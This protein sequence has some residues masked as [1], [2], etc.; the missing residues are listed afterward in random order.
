M[1][2]SID[3][4]TQRL[5]ERDHRQAEITRDTRQAA[6]ATILRPGPGG[7]EVLFIL[8]AEKEGDPWSGHMAFPGGH[9][10]PADTDLMATAARE[11]RE[12]IGIDLH[13]HGR[14]LGPLDQLSSMRRG[15]QQSLLVAPYVWVLEDD[16]DAL[17]QLNPNHEVS[18]V[19]WG[20]LDAMVRGENLTSFEKEFGGSQHTMQGY[21]VG[22]QIVW[23]L[24]FRMLREFFAVIHP[25]AAP[26]VRGK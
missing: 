9:R 7:T 10:E 17:N 11:T 12:E 19:L 22:E 25:E 14:L 18:D 15:G 4:I 20:S 3:L 23:G 8:R 21:T 6:V 16:R 26:P 2:L 5:R 13:Q 1:Q 24:T